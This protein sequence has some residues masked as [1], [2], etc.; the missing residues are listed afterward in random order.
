M[1]TTLYISFDLIQCSDIIT[2]SILTNRFLS[3]IRRDSI[4]P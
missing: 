4:A 2:K 1:K 3:I